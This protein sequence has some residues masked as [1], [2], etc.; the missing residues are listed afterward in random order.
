MMKKIAYLLF[1]LFILA[2]CQKSSFKITGDVVGIKDGTVYLQVIENNSLSKIDSTEVQ[3][4]HF[5]FSGKVEYP[6]LMFVGPTGARPKN[7]RL[8]VENK[9]IT[10]EGDIA[11][12]EKIIIQGSASQ[13]LVN[14][15]NDEQKKIEDQLKPMIK[16][17]HAEQD[18]VKKSEIRKN[19]IELSDLIIKDQ[20]RFID[21]HMDSH[22]SVYM[23][24]YDLNGQMEFSKMEELSKTFEKNFPNSPVVKVLSERVAKEKKT[25][26]GQKAPNFSVKDIDG[27]TITLD[28]FKGKYVLLDFWASWCGP[29]RREAPNFV[30]IYNKYK[31]DNFTIFGISLD[32]DEVK[33]KKGIEDM[34]FTW[35]H[36]C[37]FK[38]WKTELA[39]LYN[40]RSIPTCYLVDPNGMIVAK[41]IVGDELDKKLATLLR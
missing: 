25:A 7:I 4:G 40:V 37:D 24:T 3:N 5:E 41:G 20:I 1:S 29:C 14:T 32:K 27:N 12:A 35:N 16:A 31:N 2:S 34:G 36:T 13:D 38:V 8:Y 26:I 21:E 18:P 17:Y 22:V 10:I 23:T 39:Q 6:T 28:T 33:W 15:L 11:E 9:D 30:R 19:A